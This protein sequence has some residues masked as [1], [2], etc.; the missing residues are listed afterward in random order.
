MNTFRAFITIS[1]SPETKSGSII[2]TFIPLNIFPQVAS[3]FRV[4]FEEKRV[5]LTVLVSV[6]KGLGV[7]LRGLKLQA[8][9]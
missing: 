7:W 6:P 1:P 9:H 3:Q 8:G 2:S 5:V 4:A